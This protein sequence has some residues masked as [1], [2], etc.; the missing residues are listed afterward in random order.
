MNAADA[1]S[2][3]LLRDLIRERPELEYEFQSEVECCQKAVEVAAQKIEEARPVVHRGWRTHLILWQ[4]K[5]RAMGAELR[6]LLP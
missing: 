3:H 5:L 1:R 6:K 4:G 2:L